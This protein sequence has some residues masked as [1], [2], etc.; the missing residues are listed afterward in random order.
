MPTFMYTARDQ[1]GALKTDTIEAANREDVV[2]QLRKLRL[3]L[4]KV[5]E[6]AKANGVNRYAIHFGTAGTRK[7]Y[8]CG[9][10][11]GAESCSGTT[12]GNLRRSG[13]GGSGRRIRL[14]RVVEFDDLHTLVVLRGLLRELHEEHRTDGEVRRDHHADTRLLRKES[15][16]GVEAGVIPAGGSDHCVHAAGDYP[17]QVLQYDFGDG[18]VDNNVYTCPLEFGEVIPRVQLRDEIEVSSRFYDLADF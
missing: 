14:V 16:N 9:V 2:Q 18:E 1:K 13:A 5:E 11:L 15:T 12:G 4:V 8:R 7:C 10:G 6:A 3:N 17:F